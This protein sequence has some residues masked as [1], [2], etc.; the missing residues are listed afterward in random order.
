[1]SSFKIFVVEDDRILARRMAYE[2]EMNP[3]F[4]VE[5]FYDGESFLKRLNESPDAITLDYLLPDTT[6]AEVLIKILS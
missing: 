3:D 2:L 6:G 1:M 5:M 4:E